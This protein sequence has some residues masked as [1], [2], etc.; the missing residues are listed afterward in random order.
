MNYHTNRINYLT[1]QDKADIL[2]CA[3]KRAYTTI[4]DD[5][6]RREMT[7]ARIYSGMLA[8]T[9]ECFKNV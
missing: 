2:A 7:T 4:E 6:F 3:L 8:Q 9:L 5:R 1:T